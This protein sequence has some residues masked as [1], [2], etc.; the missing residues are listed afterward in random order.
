METRPK[1]KSAPSLTDYILDVVGWFCLVLLWGVTLSIYTNLPE[2][3]PVHFD[4]SGHP[5]SYGSKM[6]IMF[7]PVIGSLLFIGLTVLTNYPQHFNYPVN[8]TSE[9]AARQYSNATRMIRSL[10]LIITFVFSAGVFMIYQAAS[11]KSASPPFWYLAVMLG[12]III[13]LAYFIMKAVKER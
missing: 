8:I 12:S 11:G 6:T 9:N 1:L 3:I 7:L 13:P 2:I 4:L 10:K 5:N